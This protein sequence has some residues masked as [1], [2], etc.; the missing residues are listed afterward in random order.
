MIGSP[1]QRFVRTI[2][3]KNLLG[4]HTRPAT[5]IV[6]VLQR[7]KSQ[8]T[9]ACHKKSADARSILSLLMLAAHKDS[10]LTVTVEGEDA[11]ET[12]EQLI[13]LF[14]TQFGETP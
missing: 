5:L 1:S 4:L 11:F 8:V 7:F 13:L 12:M 2:Q 14:E 10:Q 6:K 9:L 3:V